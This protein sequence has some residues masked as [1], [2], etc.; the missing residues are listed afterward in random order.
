MRRRTFALLFCTAVLVTAAA[1]TPSAAL[2]VVDCPNASATS[3]TN[4]A[5]GSWDDPN[6]WSNGVPNGGCDA[7]ITL[8]G[9]YTVTMPAGGGVLSLDL[10]ASSGTQALAV[11]GSTTIA[12]APQQSLFSIGTGGVTIGIHG[13]LQYTAIGTNPGDATST[14]GGL[15]TNSGLIRTD[16]GSVAGTRDIQ[17]NVTNTATGT[18]A[19]HTDT[20]TCGCGGTHQWMNAGTIT[21]DANTVNSFTGTAGGVVYTQTGGTFTNHGRALVGG[22]V[23]HTG[24]TTTGNPIEVCGNLNAQGS[25]A[26]SFQ[27][28]YL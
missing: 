1:L 15:I 18:I 26:A 14:G 23:T 22:T 19:L 24:G 4:A 11:A 10:G 5:G 17:N 7:A 2:A 25:G 9:T 3:W 12:N 20:S 8:A 28:E 27:F 16:A 13:A 6:N 21:T